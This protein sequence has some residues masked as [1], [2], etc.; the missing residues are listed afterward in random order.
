MW[1]SPASFSHEPWGW[2]TSVKIVSNEATTDYLTRGDSICTSLDSSVLSN[3]VQFDWNHNRK[4]VRSCWIW[5][6]VISTSSS[7][8]LGGLNAQKIREAG[9]E[10]EM[11]MLWA[12]QVQLG[13][14]KREF[15]E[16][17]KRVVHN[18]CR[19]AVMVTLPKNRLQYQLD[20]TSLPA[21]LCNLQSCN[22][23]SP[24]NF[25]AMLARCLQR[26]HRRGIPNH[27]WKMWKSI[28]S[29]VMVCLE[30]VPTVGAGVI[31]VYLSGDPQ[32]LWTNKADGWGGGYGY[33]EEGLPNSWW[34]PHPPTSSRICVSEWLQSLCIVGTNHKFVSPFPASR[35]QIG[36]NCT[37]FI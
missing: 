28:E 31:S 17:F 36:L 10:W 1:S 24:D 32:P 13:P 26:N 7:R 37:R 35:F 18:F 25:E 23:K 2:S 16:G 20:T 27:W 29:R 5:R 9:K 30:L 4:S 6:W 12:R 14:L 34:Y 22:R 11:R 15:D 3:S 8:D 33:I 19:R 21:G